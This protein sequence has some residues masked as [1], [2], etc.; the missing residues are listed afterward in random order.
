M[1]SH[2]GGADTVDGTFQIGVE[3]KYLVLV[4]GKNVRDIVNL[5]GRTTL[6]NSDLCC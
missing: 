5:G 2:G 6:R 3:L 1:I 4:T